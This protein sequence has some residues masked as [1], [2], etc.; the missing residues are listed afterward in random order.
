MIERIGVGGEGERERG[1]RK[2]RVWNERENG[3][4]KIMITRE[5]GG[6]RG[7]RAET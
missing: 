3:S 2:N 4:E 1:K 7:R 5:K 6:E